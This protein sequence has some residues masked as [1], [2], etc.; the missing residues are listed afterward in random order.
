MLPEDITYIP[1]EAF[2]FWTSLT[3]ISIPKWVNRIGEDAFLGC[4]NLTSITLEAETPPI[5]ENGSLSYTV[6]DIYVPK[7][8][9]QA[10][11]KSASWEKYANKIK[12]R[13]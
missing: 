9:L 2:Y 10:Y 3:S 12:A 5:L 4:L 7:R 11:K 13:L 1:K 6:Q 8:S